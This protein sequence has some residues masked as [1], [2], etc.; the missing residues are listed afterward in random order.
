MTALVIAEHDNVSLKSATFNTVT[1][2][3][4]CGGAVHVLVAGTNAGAV[5]MAAAQ[6]A[7]VSK[8]LHTNGD[9]WDHGLAEDLTAQILDQAWSYSH[10]LFAATISSANTAPRVAAKFN[11]GLISGVVKIDSP[12]IFERSICGG[13]TIAIVQSLDAM[14]IITVRTTGFDAAPASGGNALVQSYKGFPPNVK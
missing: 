4:Q 8:V 5:A 11:V 10:I 7:G 1:A 12:D 14:K 9:V 6:I 3:A 13:N 2:A